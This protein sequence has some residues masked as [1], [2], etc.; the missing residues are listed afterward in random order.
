MCLARVH[1]VQWGLKSLAGITDETEREVLVDFIQKAEQ[2][3]KLRTTLSQTAVL[4][5][6]YIVGRWVQQAVTVTI[7]FNPE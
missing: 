2:T 1:L 7:K 3:M 5:V 6:K 4:S